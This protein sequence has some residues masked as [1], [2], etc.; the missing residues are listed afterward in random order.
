MLTKSNI[1]CESLMACET[2]WFIV[3]DS[4]IEIINTFVECFFDTCLNLQRDA[5]CTP[6]RRTNATF[7]RN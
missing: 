1:E 2:W 5:R 6:I 4:S 7:L 3:I